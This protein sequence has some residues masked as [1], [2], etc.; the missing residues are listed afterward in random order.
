MATA[1]TLTPKSTTNA[2]TLTSTGSTSLVAAACPFGVYTSSA[3]FLSGASSQVAYTYKKLGGDVLDL[4]IKADNVYA[5]Y[6]EACLEYSYILNVH[7]AKNVLSDMLGDSTGTF[8]HKGEM[9]DSTLSSSLSGTNVALKYPRIEFS[10]ARRFGQAMS[11][12]ADAGGTET[13]YSGSFERIADVQDYDL[14][15]A[16]YSASNDN[17]D[18]A[19]GHPVP[20]AGKIASGSVTKVIIK[21]VYFK[22]PHAMWRFFG[23]YGGLNTVGNLANYGQ[24]ADDS[25]FQLVPVWQNKAQSIAFEDAIYTRNSH[26]AYELH[27]NNLRIYPTPVTTSPKYFHFKFTID[28]DVWEEDGDRTTG[29]EGINNMNTLPFANISYENI[30]SIGKQWIRRF[31]LSLTKETLGQIRSKFA[32][33]PIPGE[34]VTLNGSDLMSQARE[35]QDKLRDELKTVLDELTYQK[36]LEMDATKAESVTTIQQGAPI[37]IFLG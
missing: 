28:T 34:S 16:I 1:P 15:A 25:T 31:A 26:Y 35:E 11:K 29:V 22:T 5:A 21:D 36:L 17:S 23:Y 37:P 8:D 7:Q 10:Y 20:Y 24:Y 4:E 30:N 9:S 18:P 2:S 3:G 14:Q 32:A 6:E 12:E 19:T 27:N 13:V 33:I